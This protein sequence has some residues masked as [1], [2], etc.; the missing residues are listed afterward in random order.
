MAKK[1]TRTVTYEG[2]RKKAKYDRPYGMIPK[3][4][5]NIKTGEMKY[6]DINSTY[7]NLVAGSF[8]T[9]E[10]T[11]VA[12]GTDYNERIGDDIT[13]I[14]VDIAGT[15]TTN[16]NE[17]GMYVVQMLDN[18]PPQNS[19]FATGVLGLPVK[20]T[21]INK[22][23]Y[24]GSNLGGPTNFMKK[25]R[26]QYPVKVTY[27]NTAA[28]GSIR[29]PIYFVWRQYATAGAATDVDFTFRLYYQDN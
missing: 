6:V 1:L 4:N 22:Y 28:T 24:L 26:F 9:V 23:C 16:L 20:N 10:L 27:N 29:N 17:L 8:S 3:I 18:T 19:D 2:P 11:Q 7:A 21:I 25:L 15:A 12:Q 13:V 5:R 14:G